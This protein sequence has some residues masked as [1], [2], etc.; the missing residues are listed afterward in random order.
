MRATHQEMVNRHFLTDN[1][2][3]SCTNWYICRE[4]KVENKQSITIKKIKPI[5]SVAANIKIF[6]LLQV[7]IHC[8]SK[9]VGKLFWW[10]IQQ[11]VISVRVMQRMEKY[12]V[13]AAMFMSYK[14][15]ETSRLEKRHFNYQ[16]ST[17]ARTLKPLNI[18]HRMLWPI[19]LFGP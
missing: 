5:F 14:I 18:V 8:V 1:C 7:T 17:T 13:K 3:N 15:I 11:S 2:N 6:K 16:L 4:R 12:F 10:N 19:G 9:I